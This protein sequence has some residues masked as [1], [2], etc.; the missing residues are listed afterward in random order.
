M[1]YY[2]ALTSE[3]AD[4]NEVYTVLQ[5]ALEAVTS[6]R[7]YRGP[8]RFEGD[9]LVYAN[10]VQGEFEAFEGDEQIR[11]DGKTVYSGTFSG[12]RVR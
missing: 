4:R 6:D 8:S 5:E 2:G 12:G 7:P 3:A 10:S 1:S 11:A 9:R